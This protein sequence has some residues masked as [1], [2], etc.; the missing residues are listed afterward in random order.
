MTTQLDKSALQHLHQWIQSSSYTPSLQEQACLDAYSRQTLF[1]GISL[2]GLFTWAGIVT[3]KPTI[4]MIVDARLKKLPAP[5]KLRELLLSI[6]G[7]R[8]IM[9][10]NIRPRY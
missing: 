6:G 2:M 10:I 3:T 9:S 1:A 7:K 8:P 4:E 5:G